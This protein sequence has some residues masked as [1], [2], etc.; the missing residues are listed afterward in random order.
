MKLVLVTGFMPVRSTRKR[1]DASTFSISG[2]RS[3]G[4]VARRH[5][6]WA[7]SILLAA[8]RSKSRAMRKRRAVQRDTSGNERCSA[9]MSA[10]A[11]L[12]TLVSTG[13]A[14]AGG[15]VVMT[16]GS[17]SSP[18]VTASVGLPGLS[19]KSSLAASAV[20]FVM[21]GPRAFLVHDELYYTYYQFNTVKSYW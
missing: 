2:V 6:R 5:S 20:D 9:A 3:M 4:S 14:A 7:C 17:G 16:I 21:S 8:P 1:G 10:S 19:L 13:A 11:S 15:S 18:L 12:V